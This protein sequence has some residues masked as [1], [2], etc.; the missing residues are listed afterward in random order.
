MI[1]EMTDVNKD[2]IQ[3]KMTVPALKH[4]IPSVD[5]ENGIVTVNEDRL[6]E[7]AVCDWEKE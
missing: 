3:G 5:V 2:Y 7:V 1:I 4:V 6:P